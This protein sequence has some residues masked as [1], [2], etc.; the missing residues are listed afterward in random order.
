MF[1]PYLLTWTKYLLSGLIHG[2]IREKST[3]DIKC[4]VPC[5]GLILHAYQWLPVHFITLC[6]IEIKVI[7]ASISRIKSGHALL[8]SDLPSTFAGVAC[9]CALD[10]YWRQL[11]N[12]Q[13]YQKAK[14]LILETPQR[15]MLLWAL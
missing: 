12:P 10:N 14:P 4:S 1:S 13:L 7:C 9:P 5:L 8:Q 6:Q 3:R 15:W 2:C 11:R